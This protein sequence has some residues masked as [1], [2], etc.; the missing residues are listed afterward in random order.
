MCLACGFY[1]GRVVI[2][3]KAKQAARLARRNARLEAINE[4]VAQFGDTP[5]IPA[6]KDAK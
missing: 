6:Q 1:K 3:M 4:Q 2:D 5:A